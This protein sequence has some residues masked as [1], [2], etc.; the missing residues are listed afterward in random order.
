MDLDAK[1][2]AALFNGPHSIEVQHVNGPLLVDETL[3]GLFNRPP[4]HVMSGLTPV[5]SASPSLEL[6]ESAAGNV[7][8]N[9]VFT[10]SGQTYQ[11]AER[12]AAEYGIVEIRLKAQ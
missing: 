1:L 9:S 6:L 11:I 8:K 5:K 12:K 7:D 3:R 10:I 4:A 2:N